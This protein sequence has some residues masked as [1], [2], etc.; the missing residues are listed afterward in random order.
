MGFVLFL[1]EEG[2]RDGFG[3]GASAKS[4]SGLL[5]AWISP[6][7]VAVVMAKVE[8]NASDGGGSAGRG[9]FWSDDELVGDHGN[10]YSQQNGGFIEHAGGPKSLKKQ[11]E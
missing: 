8:F 1:Q 10:D 2:L 5:L 11:A 6:A 4:L 9:G 7:A 3:R